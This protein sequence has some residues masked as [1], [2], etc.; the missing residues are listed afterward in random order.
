MLL[1]HHVGSHFQEQP[2]LLTTEPSVQFWIIYSSSS[3][4][5]S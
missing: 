4:C 3:F 2:V 1:S 5:H